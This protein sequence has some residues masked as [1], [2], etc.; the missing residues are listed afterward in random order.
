MARSDLE[1]L[2][3]YAKSREAE[4][5]AELVAR[6][7][8]MVYGTCYRLLGSRPD[9]E[10]A[11]QECFVQLA[12][13]GACV[14]TSVSGWLHRVA[15]NSSMAQRRK[16]R[17]RERAEREA[18]G[19][20]PD[21]DT[22]P[23][24]DK[25][26][27]EVDQ[28]IDTLP[29]DLREPLVLHFLQGK[30]QTAVAEELGLS[31]SAVSKRVAKAVE[32]LRR[33]LGPLG[34][35]L[36]VAG[37]VA[38]LETH[39]AEAAPAT[40]VANLG[41]MALA[42]IPPAPTAGSASSFLGPAASMASSSK[43]L[44][45]LMAAL[46][47]GAIVQQVAQVA[48]AAARR[49]VVREAGA[50]PAVPAEA[51]SLARG[52]A[53]ARE[54][55]EAAGPVNHGSQPR[56][57]PGEPSRTPPGPRPGRPSR[58][59]RSSAPALGASADR[60]APDRP[61]TPPTRPAEGPRAVERPAEGASLLASAAT[62]SLTQAT[63]LA[64]G[65]LP[66]GQPPLP[67]NS[68]NVA[69]LPPGVDA[70]FVA[71]VAKI[72]AV[73]KA[74]MEATFP[75]RQVETIN[76]V[77]AR[78]RAAAHESVVTDRRDTIYIRAD[79]RGIG[80]LLRP[81]AG[82]VAI[83]CEAVADLSN[84]Q[85]LAGFNRF[86]AHRYLVPA[87]AGE[88]PLGALADHRALRIMADDGPGMLTAM[89]EPLYSSVHP[90]FA[91]VTALCAIEKEL[92][93]EGLRA[94]LD[95]IPADAEDPFDALRAAAT[96]KAPQLAEAFA[97]YDEAM[98][99]AVDEEGSCL[100]ASFEPDETIL[101]AHPPRM[102][103]ETLRL[104]LSPQNRWSL[105]DEW[106]THGA[107]SLCVEADEGAPW[108]SVVID[109]A[110]W[111][112]RDWRRFSEFSFD[113]LVVSPEPQAIGFCAQDHPTCGHGILELF[114]DT[115]QSGEAHHVSFPLNEESLRGS[116]D[117]D[118]TYFSGAFRADSVSR[119]YIGLNKPTQPITLYLDNLRLKVRP[120]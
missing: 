104:I 86:V 105:S 69:P 63:G 78:A 94:L 23:T 10:D 87:V 41:R 59:A 57:T 110:D 70:E 39:S 119:L 33:H 61:L 15:V 83:L 95:E 68:V 11:A 26:K 9:A 102:A 45:L 36:S 21:R 116:Q 66:V 76:L 77:F 28:A 62:P 109:D 73:A 81:D 20:V 115:V 5:F 89:A 24:W 40:L 2:T 19:M 12:R 85:P 14:R 52:P 71:T 82:P 7:R 1:L 8:D 35:A 64:S 111:K 112:F 118:A 56:A 84:P 34:S 67:P 13:R 113:F 4:A 55:P 65:L 47:V 43:V 91:A 120:N 42:G 58:A 80:E 17:A 74:A 99:L 114:A 79:D 50:A 48:P 22:E 51:P 106:S 18:G 101:E 88:M 93:L 72:V 117:M 98:R 6:H 27:A 103:T 31:Q 32:R 37:L 60:P 108:M 25:I 107:Q 44:C 100:I 49:P 46:T 97:A 38:L 92:R 75:G 29:D 3:R 54:R 90:D 16:D 53:G 96:A 30:P